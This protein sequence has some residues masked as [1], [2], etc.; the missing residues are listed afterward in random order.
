MS[1]LKLLAE[2]MLKN[3]HLGT[4]GTRIGFLTAY[5][6]SLDRSTDWIIR[7][8]SIEG[9]AG[10]HYPPHRFRTSPYSKIG[11]GDNKIYWAVHTPDAELVKA[12][13]ANVLA[14]I[15]NDW[16]PSDFQGVQSFQ[17]SVET[18]TALADALND[19]ELL[20]RMRV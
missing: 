20:D 7:H 1:S 9:N 3:A 11:S 19:K 10:C 15:P 2:K 5:L 13:A 18:L 8:V 6:E 12:A 4:G 16:V 14:E 17:I